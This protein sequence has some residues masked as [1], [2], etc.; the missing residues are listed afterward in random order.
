MVL[1]TKREQHIVGIQIC[2]VLIKPEVDSSTQEE[3]VGKVCILQGELSYTDS[4]GL[5]QRGS[6]IGGWVSV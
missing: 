2:F 5:Q 6:G 3:V 4:T 1:T